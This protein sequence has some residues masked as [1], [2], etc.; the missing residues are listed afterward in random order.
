MVWWSLAFA[1]I[2]GMAMEFLVHMPPPPPATQTAE[3]IKQWY[4]D[5]A[6]DIRIGA[7]IASWTSG[8]LVPF[9][10]VV[11][12]QIA[13]L[14]GRHRVW[15]QMANIGGALSSLFLVLPPLSFGVAASPRVGTPKSQRSCT[16]AR[17][18]GT[19]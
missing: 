11:G 17:S 1:T 13:R 7:T 19:A 14:E 12:A 5:R 6:G 18:P 2:Y 4:L 8:F 15:S 16:S 10:I 3:Q 9:F